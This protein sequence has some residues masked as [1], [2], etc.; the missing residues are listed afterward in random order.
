MKEDSGQ[1]QF[2]GVVGGS[3]TKHTGS[4]HQKNQ[5]SLGGSFHQHRKSSTSPLNRSPPNR[6]ESERSNDVLLFAEKFN[7]VRFRD[8]Q[9]NTRLNINNAEYAE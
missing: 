7:K 8:F 2:L 3:V 1:P 4:G 9:N 6:R 5:S